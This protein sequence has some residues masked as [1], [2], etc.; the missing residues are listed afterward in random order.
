MRNPKIVM[1][2]GVM[3]AASPWCDNCEGTGLFSEEELCAFCL[4]DSILDGV[5]DGE[6][7]GVE[8]VNGVVI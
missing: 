5:T 2:L 3:L 6:I 8:Y 4:E 7:D 1:V